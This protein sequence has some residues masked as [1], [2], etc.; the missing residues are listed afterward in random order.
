MI[1]H[2]KKHIGWYIM[3]PSIYLLFAGQAEIGIIIFVVLLKMPPFDLI[4]RYENWLYK[5]MRV[6]GKGR[7]WLFHQN[8]EMREKMKN[9]TK[10]IRVLFSLLVLILL[11]LFLLFFMWNSFR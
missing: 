5:R 6:E 4:G 8:L 7:H 10:Y 9:K 3:M 11:I 2:L 1:N